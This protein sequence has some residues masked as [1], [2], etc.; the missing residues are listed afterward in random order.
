[1]SKTGYFGRG[2]QVQDITVDG[3]IT[4]IVKTIALIHQINPT[5]IPHLYKFLPQL[6]EMLSGFRKEYP[7][8]NKKYPVEVD[9]PEYLG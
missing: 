2:K 8:K 1:M 6:Q 7:A 5:K 4:A 9:V 3:A